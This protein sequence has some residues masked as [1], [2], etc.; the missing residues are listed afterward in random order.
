M[1]KYKKSD[2][3]SYTLGTTVTIELL[4]NKPEY[5]TEVFIHSK[6][7]NNETLNKIMDLCNKNNILV[8]KNDKVFAVLSD[9]ENCYVIGVF[10]KY[11]SIVDY[12]ANHL[13]LVNPSNAGNLGTIMRTSLGFGIRDIMIVREAVDYF[14]PKTIRA[15]M[16]AIFCLNVLLIDDIEEYLKKT[17]NR[18]LF[19]FML[20]GKE[21]LDEINDTGTFTLIFGNEAKGLPKKYEEIGRS[22]VIKHSS[23][24]DSLNLDNAVSIALYEFTKNK[25]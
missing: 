13:V 17:T 18:T 10:N 25:R 21:G 7:E 23:L 19:P 16:G 12:S 2:S 24:I 22:V 9:K 14:D 8:T 4:I 15:S 1:K 11:D 20:N 6:Q 5:V 3:V